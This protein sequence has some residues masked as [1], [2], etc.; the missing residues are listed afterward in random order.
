MVVIMAAASAVSGLDPA[1]I[2]FLGAAFGGAGL[3]LTEA[4][5][6]RNKVKIDDASQIRDELRLEIQSQR[7]EIRALE[8]EVH[9]WREQY[10]ALR[11]KY[12][13]LQL[14][15]LKRVD[16]IKSEVAVYDTAIE[17]V[18]PTISPESPLTKTDE[19]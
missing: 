6:G 14:D 4:W 10:Y 17:K 3:K 12:M 7:E 19:A 18:P 16:T 13:T 9:K 8:A 15:L 11:D 1:W 5:L 2:A